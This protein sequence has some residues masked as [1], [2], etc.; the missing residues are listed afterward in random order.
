LPRSAVACTSWVVAPA[1][2]GTK[3]YGQLKLKSLQQDSHNP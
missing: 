1:K 2:T 3:G